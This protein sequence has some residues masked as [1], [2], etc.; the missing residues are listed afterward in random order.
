VCSY[1][2]ASKIHAYKVSST[3]PR[4]VGV[5]FEPGT[6]VDGHKKEK[7]NLSQQKPP[8]SLKMHKEKT[9]MEGN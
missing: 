7:G 4:E 8:W 1:P 3:S 2:A 9:G 6:T 5:T